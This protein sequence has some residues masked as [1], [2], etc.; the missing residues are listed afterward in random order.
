MG[1]ELKFL[2]WAIVLGLVQLLLANAL[3][4]RQRGLA[5]N[6]GPRD[7]SPPL[8]GVAGRSERAYRN[9]L[10]TFPF[11]AAAVLAVPVAGR[12]DENSAL[13]V[14]LYFWARVA[15]VPLYLGAIR[16]VRS[17]AWVVS[18]AGLALVLSPLLH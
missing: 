1:I 18:M 8:T 3:V 7:S 2:V 6:T 16:Y 11:F 10:E 17:L 9:F 15:Y 5:W 13:G 12:A 4:T 14:Q